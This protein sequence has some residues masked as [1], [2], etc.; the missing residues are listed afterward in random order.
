MW[1]LM[2]GVVLYV[3]LVKVFVKHPKHY[4]IG[5]TVLSYGVPALYMLFIVPIGFLVNTSDHSHYLYYDDNGDLVA[6][7][8]NYESGFIWSFI[9]PV[10]LIIL[11]NVGFLVMAIVIMKRHQ[12]KQIHKK[13]SFQTKYWI[14]AF[15]SLTIVMGIGYIVNILFFTRQLI[16]IAYISTIFTAGQGIIIFILYVPL[17]SNVREAYVRWWKKKQANSTILSRMRFHSSSD[18]MNGIKKKKSVVENIY[19][20]YTLGTYGGEDLDVKIESKDSSPSPSSTLS[21]V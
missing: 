10:I 6:C 9:G 2:E 5:F 4:I 19:G 17:S 13:Q 8:L 16:F 3:S 14:K 1:M 21:K 18:T 20:Q 12:K 11:A 7:W 15:L